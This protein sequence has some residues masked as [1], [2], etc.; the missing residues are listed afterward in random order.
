MAGFL[1]NDL[2]GVG[3]TPANDDVFVIQQDGSS[4]VKKVSYSE[5]LGTTVDQS[6]IGV[7]IASLVNGTV[8]TAQLPSYVDD[9]IEATTKTN[10]PAGET[11]KLYVATNT[12]KT[13]RWSG[14]AFIEIGSGLYA[15]DIGVSVQG[16][17]ANTVVDASYVHTDNN[18]T[19]SLK[20]NYDAAYSHSQSA[21]A[22]SD[23]DKTSTNETSHLNVVVDASYVHTDTNY[24]AADKTK[25]DFI[26]VTGAV[27]LDTVVVDGDIGITVQGYDVN[28]VVDANYSTLKATINV[29]GDT[30]SRPASPTLYQSYFDT[31][32]TKPIWH[33]GTNWVDATGATV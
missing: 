31:D 17:D 25:V 15:T 20:T 29:G 12:N 8:P 19:S 33:D 1:P 6:E 10:F 7:S 27:D 18:F 16:Y 24:V 5:I 32:L 21:H 11:G 30:A 13:F 26:S 22:P 2:T 9:V 23:A 3:A 14:S 28:T 4:E